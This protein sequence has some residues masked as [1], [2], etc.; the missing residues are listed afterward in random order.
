M[1]KIDT[2]QE[3]NRERNSFISIPLR[4]VVTAII[5]PIKPII[6]PLAPTAGLLNML[7]SANPATPDKT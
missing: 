1:A 4:F 6:A 7:L 3:I 2:T 5:T